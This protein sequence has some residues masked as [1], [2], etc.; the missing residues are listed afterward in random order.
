MRDHELNI[1]KLKLPYSRLTWLSI[2]GSSWDFFKEH[3][4]VNSHSYFQLGR[5]GE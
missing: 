3:F 1:E 2:V 5:I 4:L